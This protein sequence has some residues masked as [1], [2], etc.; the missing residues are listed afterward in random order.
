MNGS[1]EPRLKARACWS[2][3]NTIEVHRRGPGRRCP[4]VEN[5]AARAYAQPYPFPVRARPNPAWTVV[6]DPLPRRESRLPDC[7]HVRPP[8]Q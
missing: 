7:G 2:G 1:Y 3:G 5:N 6:L 4:R 8:G